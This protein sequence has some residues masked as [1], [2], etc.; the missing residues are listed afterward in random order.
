MTELESLNALVVK[1]KYTHSGMW[2]EIGNYAIFT[3]AGDVL[4]RVQE[5]MPVWALLT[6]SIFRSWHSMKLLIRNTAGDLCF[7]LNRPWPF[8][9]DNIHVYDAEGR[10]LGTSKRGVLHMM[11]FTVV[12]YTGRA[13]YKVKGRFFRKSRWKIFDSNG[14]TVGEITKHWAGLKQEWRSDADNFSVIF[15]QGIPVEHKVLLLSSLLHIDI[16]FFEKI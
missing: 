10:F 14:T 12:D 6:R 15:P 16:I 7:T 1:E 11:T 8:Y 9:S 5:D 3:P 13:I 2:E 4:Y